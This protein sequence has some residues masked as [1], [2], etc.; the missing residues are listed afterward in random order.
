MANILAVAATAGTSSDVTLA[1]GATANLCL[2]ASGEIPAD[3]IGVVLVDTSVGTDTE[4]HRLT[5]DAPCVKVLGPGTFRV[6]RAAGKSF[7]V[8]SL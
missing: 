2:V 4:I 7:G 3:S 6:F 8:D 1:D 5:K